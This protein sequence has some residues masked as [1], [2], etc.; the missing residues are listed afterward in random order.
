MKRIGWAT[1]GL[2]CIALAVYVFVTQH[3][4]WWPFAVFLIAPDLTFVLGFQPGLQRGQLAPRAVP[5]YNAAHR[6]W[7]PAV[8]VV[9][10]S[11]LGAWAWTAAGL[12]WC[13]HIGIDRS[14]GFTLRTPEGFFRS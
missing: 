4:A 13:A 14:L 5:F 12:A 3:A 2:A 7:A 11:V 9:L 10:A 8:L 6:F 1:F